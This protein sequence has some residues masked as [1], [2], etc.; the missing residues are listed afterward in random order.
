MCDTCSLF[1]SRMRSLKRDLVGKVAIVTG[2]RIKIGFETARALL[3]NGATVIATSRFT[4]DA[5]EKY[6]E[7]DDFEDW[8]SRLFIYPL[9]LKDGDSILSFCAYVKNN[10]SKIDI[11]IN[12]AAQTV[13]RPLKYYEKLLEKE[14]SNLSETHLGEIKT[15]DSTELVLKN[16][17]KKI[18]IYSDELSIKN[19]CLNITEH[20]SLTKE[21]FDSNLHSMFPEGETDQFGEQKDNRTHHSWTYLLPEIDAIELLETTMINNIA[22]TIIVSQLMDIMKPK[23]EDLE[24]VTAEDILT[25]K[26]SSY[27]INVVSHEGIFNIDGKTDGHVHTNM[28]KAALNMLTRSAS[29]YYA[30]NGILMNSC[31]T[32]WISSAIKTFMKPPLTVKDGA[33]RI[34]YPI[35]TCSLDYGK[36]YK[37]YHESKW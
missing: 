26:N 15:N 34:L 9:N 29:N 12:N 23:V 6:A 25:G 21:D 37:N 36:L 33:Y 16:E 10:F 20:Y 30:K 18:V 13:R 11:L 19:H 22:P 27:I 5:Y 8:Q 35:L 31:D 1:N 17:N 14:K 4:H 24:N 7:C 32:G 2:A 28:S 3:K